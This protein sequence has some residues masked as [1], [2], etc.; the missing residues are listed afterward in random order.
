M[1]HLLLFFYFLFQI[2]HRFIPT[3]LFVVLYNFKPR[4]ADELD[5]KYDCLYVMAILILKS[6][7][8]RAG[9]KLTVIDTSDKDWWKGKCLGSVGFFPSTYVTKLAP[10]E[11]PLQVLQTV[12]IGSPEGPIKL[13]RDQVT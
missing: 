10:G 11:K 9:Y 13:L 8:N 12:Q 4:Q 1:H 7:F 2:S 3:N 6:F 5:L